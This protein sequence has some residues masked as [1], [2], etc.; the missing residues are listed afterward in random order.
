LLTVG[1]AEK[2][3]PPVGAGDDRLLGMLLLV[4]EPNLNTSAGLGVDAVKEKLLVDGLEPTDAENV[5]LGPELNVGALGAEK[6]KENLLE[7]EAAASVLLALLRLEAGRLGVEDPDADLLKPKTVAGSTLGVDAADEVLEVAPKVNLGLSAG[8]ADEGPA[9]VVVED[10]EGL[11]V[12]EPKEKLNGF[13]GSVGVAFDDAA[14]VSSGLP[15][16]RAGAGAGLA[17]LV[18]KPVDAAAF[19][20]VSSS[21]FFFSASSCSAFFFASSLRFNSSSSA[22]FLAMASSS[23]RFFS[24]SALRCASSS[25]LFCSASSLIC[26]CRARSRSCRTR[27]RSCRTRSRSCSSFILRCRS[28]SS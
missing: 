13:V 11:E 26:S 14:F 24:S 7:P 3:K 25:F 5:L 9:V 18:S 16:E 27:S 10:V 23:L 19:L 21:F 1:A 22:F 4:A 6:L 28:L 8:G 15:K 17:G 20:R 2:L 12:L